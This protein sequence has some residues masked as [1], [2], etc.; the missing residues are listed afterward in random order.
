MI[1]QM[2]R[3]P[4][5][6]PRPELDTVIREYFDGYD[7]DIPALAESMNLT[8][9]E[10]YFAV[11]DPHLRGNIKGFASREDKAIINERN[12]RI[13]F[14]RNTVL[15]S[16]AGRSPLRFDHLEEAVDYLRRIA[17][18]GTLLEMFPYDN[19][20][21]SALFSLTDVKGEQVMGVLSDLSKIQFQKIMER[22]KGLR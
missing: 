15:L 9:P 11:K 14:G 10:M 2:L 7:R 6:Q 1:W 22:F 19:T 4:K 13:I 20:H 12:D 5:E 18:P 16:I 17:K 3:K 8:V 21:H